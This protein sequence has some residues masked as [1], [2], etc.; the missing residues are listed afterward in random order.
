MLEDEDKTRKRLRAEHDVMVSN[1]EISDANIQPSLYSGRAPNL[2]SITRKCS[3]QG[4]FGDVRETDEN[5]IQTRI[6]QILFGK[7]TTGYDNYVSTVPK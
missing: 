5:R 7:N 6:K 1:I 3:Y 4:K 2:T